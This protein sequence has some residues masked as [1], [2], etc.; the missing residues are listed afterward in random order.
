MVH[1]DLE[2]TICHGTG[3]YNGT[4][5]DWCNGVGF[6]EIECD[7]LNKNSLCYRAV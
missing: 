4:P 5:C 6:I 3:Y 2:C 7:E 1:A